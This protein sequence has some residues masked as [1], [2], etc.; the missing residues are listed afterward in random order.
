MDAGL[1]S[2]RGP[3]E[4]EFAALLLG[5]DSVYR[6]FIDPRRLCECGAALWQSAREAP[7]DTERL[8]RWQAFVRGI[9]A[10]APDRR[11][12]LKSP[13]HTFRLPLLL[14]R[15][16]R[17]QF[18][19]IGRHSGETL[20]SNLKMWRT[21]MTRYAQWNCPAGLLEAFLGDA[22]RACAD[23]LSRC[24]DEMSPEQLLWV[25][26][27][28]LHSEPRPVLRAVLDFLQPSPIGSDSERERQLDAALQRTPVHAGSRT[29][30]ASDPNTERLDRLMVA[31]RQR[32]GERAVARLSSNR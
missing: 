20:A 27:A 2:S 23:V 24:L 12:L 10:E 7:A 4:D 11:L 21:M 28:A 18:V 32:F 26:F 1:I 17:A 22:L 14:R 15:F 8:P 3:Q 9:A 16:P 6:S 25:D 13:N 30:A 5:E 19:W 31:A 29:L